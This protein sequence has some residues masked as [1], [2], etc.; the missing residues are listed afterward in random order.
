MQHRR[1]HVGQLAQ[2]GEADRLDDA[3]IRHEARIRDREAGD[4]RPV[5]VERRADAA[6]DDRAGDVGAAAG[7]GAH[8]SVCAA[9]V[10][11]RDDRLREALRHLAD[12]RVGARLVEASGGVEEDDI[13][14]VDKG[15]AEV[16]RE[17]A[18]V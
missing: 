1:A 16:G 11:A 7:E 13:R 15:E 17:Q 18:A 5:L 2:L 4:V 12:R 9:A 8:A 14:R 10:K 3:R 6:R